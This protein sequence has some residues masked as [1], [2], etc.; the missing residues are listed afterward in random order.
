MEVP[1][2]IT[3]YSYEF[4]SADV[5]DRLGYSV[6]IDGPRAAIG[7]PGS[8]S[9][10][11]EP[12]AAYVVDVVTGNLVLKLS[13]SDAAP[14]HAFGSSIAIN[15]SFIVV[16][17]SHDIARGWGTGSA[18]VFD[19]T[20]G[21]QRFKLIGADSA[22]TDL[23]GTSLAITGESV[24]VGA[25]RNRNAGP[26]A[27]SAY[28]FSATTGQ[29]A[30]Q[31]NASYAQPSDRFGSSVAAIGN[32]ALVG[33]PSGFAVSP[34]T[35]YL[36]DLTSGQQLSRLTAAD[37]VNGDEFGSAVAIHGNVAIVGA[38]RAGLSG[39]AFVFD[40]TDPSDPVLLRKLTASD[41]SSGDGLGL[42]ATVHGSL[43]IIGAP[44]DDDF[45]FNSGSAYLFDV[46]TGAQL[47]KFQPSNPSDGLF[48]W[49]ATISNDV[50]LVGAPF[51]NNA[52]G[53]AYVFFLVPEPNRLLMSFVGAV[54]LL[55]AI[56]RCRRTRPASQRKWPP[57][58]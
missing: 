50:V 44:G 23:F 47:G 5:T 55:P 3:R 10:S 30:F 34:G 22:G 31:L 24:I 1:A 43:A 35:A 45:G 25:P 49:S 11:T 4:T 19:A 12:G 42:S 53:S 38:A 6:A 46:Y 18:Y 26:D 32:L 51:E 7:A 29:Q 52:V 39:A 21:E 37:V 40:V 8:P 33:A 20:T 15:S 14:N 17:S 41:G 28:V 56:R 57:A 54:L 9:T 48:G 36:F 58:V 2:D 13:A 27:G 16:G